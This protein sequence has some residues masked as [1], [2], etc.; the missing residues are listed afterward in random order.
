VSESTTRTATRGS[1][2]GFMLCTCNGTIC[3][4]PTTRVLH[5]CCT[6]AHRLVKQVCYGTVHRCNHGIERFS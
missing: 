1:C 3:Y 2:S 4:M 6:G 5:A